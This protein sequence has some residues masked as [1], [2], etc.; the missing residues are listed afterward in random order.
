MKLKQ[1]YR[2]DSGEVIEFRDLN[3]AHHS[4]KCRADEI[5]LRDMSRPD[6]QEIRQAIADDINATQTREFV[7]EC[8]TVFI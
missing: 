1:H 2:L 6:Q 7:S 8:K 3:A 4:K 5:I